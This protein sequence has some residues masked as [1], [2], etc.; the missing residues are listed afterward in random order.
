MLERDKK[1]LDLISILG[2]CTRQQIQS[3]I[4]VNLH[5]N[6]CLRRLAIL[7]KRNLIKRKYFN[8]GGNKN[9]YVYYLQDEPTKDRVQSDLIITEY[10]IKLMKKS[11]ILDVKRNIIPKDNTSNAIIKF[12]SKDK[13]KYI[14]LKLENEVNNFKDI[15]YNFKSQ[16]NYEIPNTLYLI[17]I[18]LNVIQK[19]KYK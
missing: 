1:V 3:I 2:I 16:V 18:N 19:I 6:V 10:I 8:L 5:E 11:N 17:D 15:Y 9:A 4:F 12:K 13:I 7:S 14:F